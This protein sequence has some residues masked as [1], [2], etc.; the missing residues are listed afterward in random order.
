MTT[1]LLAPPD[2]LAPGLAAALGALGRATAELPWGG[3]LS[4]GVDT[5]GHDVLVTVAPRPRLGPL[6]QIGFDDWTAVIRD[7]AERPA[8]A[9]RSLLGAGGTRWIAVIPHLSSLPSPGS[10][11]YGAG[12]V[13]LQTVLRVSV[14]ENA[15]TGFCA[16]AIAV[17]PFAG[18]LEGDAERIARED[19]PRGSLTTL[20]GARRARALARRRGPRVAE[21]RDAQARRRVLAH[22]QAP[23]G[24]L[25]GDRRLARRAGVAAA[26]E[27]IS[28]RAV[29]HE[30]VGQAAVAL[31][32][33]TGDRSDERRAVARGERV[34]DRRVLLADQARGRGC[35]GRACAGRCAPRS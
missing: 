18:S 29:A 7:I 14:I 2:S 13:L 27:L 31:A 11:P 30:I 19:T 32:R 24:A 20:G 4:A 10:G 1:A 22:P 16:N 3:D 33:V 12:G 25:G 26:G 21:R 8:A 35:R 6:A 15:A 17:G 34:D 23:P 28:G 5:A 9:A